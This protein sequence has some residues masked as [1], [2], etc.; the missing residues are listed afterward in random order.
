MKEIY[1][2]LTYTGTILSNIIKTYTKDEYSHVSI[3]LDKELN[4]M[5]SFGRLKPYNAFIGGFVHEKIN[6]GIFKRFRNTK[7]MIYSLKVEEEQYRKIKD[8]ITEM[9]QEK[10]T[11]KFNIWGL[12][13]VS[14]NKKIKAP[15]TFYCAEF[16]KY[17]LEEAGVELEL[18]E[19]IRPQNFKDIP[20]KKIQYEGLLRDF[21]KEIK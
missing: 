13:A 2:I 17:I 10:E 21:K 14:I 11:Y 9:E 1:I 20:N 6:E 8:K 18:P 19:I 3:S 15:R 7:A 12:F 16:V 5:Y 4:K